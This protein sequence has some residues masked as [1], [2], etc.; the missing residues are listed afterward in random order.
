MLE[1]G[2]F[3]CSVFCCI[4]GTCL[5]AH[6]FILQ[7]SSSGGGV[8]LRAAET[9]VVYAGWRL[10]ELLWQCWHPISGMNCLSAGEVSHERQVLLSGLSS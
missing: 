2:R 7:H 1:V 5:H 4:L 6:F 9:T 10:L 3:T 8:F